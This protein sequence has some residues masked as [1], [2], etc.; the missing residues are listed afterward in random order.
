MS[1]ASSSSFRRRA[2]SSAA[3]FFLAASSS[4]S[5]WRC[6]SSRRAA[7]LRACAFASATCRLKAASSW[8]ACHFAAPSSAKRRS[9]S[10]CS[11]RCASA[12]SGRRLTGT[13]PA[14]SA[15]AASAVEAS[16]S[17]SSSAS[18]SATA[19][20][21]ARRCAMSGQSLELRYRCCLSENRS[22]LSSTIETSLRPTRSGRPEANFRLTM[23]LYSSVEEARLSATILRA[24]TSH[25]GRASGFRMMAALR[26]TMTSSLSFSFSGCA[27]LFGGARALRE[28]TSAGMRRCIGFASL[29][30]QIIAAAG[31][32]GQE[33]AA[34]A[35]EVRPGHTCTGAGGKGPLA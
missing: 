8:A 31:W 18:A 32:G 19:S 5:C 10:S 28:T 27:T 7:S 12:G 6:F 26:S 29:A 3:A 23:M 17:A 15:R 35:N 22:M 33:R 20:A 1:S 21:R 34:A 30:S 13:W 14:A 24:L 11:R 9:L 16:R 4:A 25:L 2:A